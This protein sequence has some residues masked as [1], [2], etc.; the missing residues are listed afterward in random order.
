[1]QSVSTNALLENS[2]LMPMSVFALM[3]SSDME[4]YADS[5]LLVQPPML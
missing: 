1:M 3:D 2:T 5:A 4:E